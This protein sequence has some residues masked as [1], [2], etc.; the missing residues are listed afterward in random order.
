MPNVYL[1]DSRLGISYQEDTDLKLWLVKQK[2]N[3]LILFGGN[4]KEMEEYKENNESEILAAYPFS[5]LLLNYI[6]L[7]GD[8]GALPILPI[9][10]Y[11]QASEQV[12]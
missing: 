5:E 10:K 8:R 6:N 11:I 2:G 4:E 1:H 9:N 12:L 3:I 7:I